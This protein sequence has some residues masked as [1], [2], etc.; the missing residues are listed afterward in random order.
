MPG[1]QREEEHDGGA[2]RAVVGDAV[3]EGR[4]AHR[5]RAERQSRPMISTDDNNP[6][7]RSASL[8]A[9]RRSRLGGGA[10]DVGRNTRRRRGPAAGM[11]RPRPHPRR[12]P[13]PTCP[14]QR[15]ARAWPSCSPRS[16][17]GPM[18]RA[19]GG[20]SSC[21]STPTSR[22]VRRVNSAS[23]RWASS[24]RATRRRRPTSRPWQR[25]ARNARPRWPARRRDRRRA[26]QRRGRR[27]GAASGDRG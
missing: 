20:R 19:R 22:R 25:P 2:E 12:P 6:P 1:R 15:P 18:A 7:G 21:A 23:A 24:S 14:R 26:P 3:H 8:R 5:A 4:L 17:S 13:R 27:G 16:S 9:A 10:A 11:V